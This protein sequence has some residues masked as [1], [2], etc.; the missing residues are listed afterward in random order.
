MVHVSDNT[1]EVDVSWHHQ[2]LVDSKLKR[3]E[4][5]TVPV[6]IWVLL[7]LILICTLSPDLDVSELAEQRQLSV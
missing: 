2:Y 6:A 5:Q 1:E 4:W 3:G 7:N